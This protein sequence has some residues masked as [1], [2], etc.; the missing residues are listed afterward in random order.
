MLTRTPHTHDRLPGEEEGT[1][2]IPR[3]FAITGEKVPIQQ[4]EL[5]SGGFNH[6]C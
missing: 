6:H 1:R 3:G 2:T 4:R 5:L